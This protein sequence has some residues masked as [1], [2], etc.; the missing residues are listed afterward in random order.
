MNHA[1]ST[2]FTIRKATLADCNGVLECLHLAFEPFKSSYTPAAYDDTVLSKRTLQN[3]LSEMAVYVAISELEAV[4]GTVACK[5]IDREEGH[6]RGM[7]VVPTWQGRG[8]AQQLLDRAESELRQSN[9]KRITLDTTAPLKRAVRF[10][11]RNGFRATGRVNDFF[12]MPLFE[13][14]K[15]A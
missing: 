9:C 15:K 6:L 4:V 11:E 12:G 14:A 10:Y 2:H 3:R 1:G 7:A 13:Y 8:V 5:M